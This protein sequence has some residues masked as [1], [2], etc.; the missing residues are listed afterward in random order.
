[1]SSTTPPEE[2]QEEVERPRMRLRRQAPVAPAEPLPDKKSNTVHI[3]INANASELSADA[4]STVAEHI[5]RNA[6][7]A[8]NAFSAVSEGMR[9]AGSLTEGL[10]GITTVNYG[11]VAT[12]EAAVARARQ[13]LSQ[14]YYGLESR[15]NRPISLDDASAAAGV[16]PTSRSASDAITL[17]VD[18]ARM[19]IADAAGSYVNVP[20]APSGVTRESWRRNGQ[21]VTTES[22]IPSGI[23][24]ALHRAWTGRINY[25]AI[26][27]RTPYSRHLDLDELRETPIA[28]VLHAMARSIFNE[29]EG[30]GGRY[31]GSLPV[32]VTIRN[33]F[34]VLTVLRVPLYVATFHYPASTLD[35]RALREQTSFGYVMESMPTGRGTEE[36]RRAGV[37]IGYTEEQ[38]THVLPRVVSDE[39]LQGVNPDFWLGVM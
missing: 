14:Q 3:T 17:G 9:R 15:I 30:R 18:F 23:E 12:R 11:S 29:L 8:S 39:M 13:D 27:G 5:R 32:S 31:T 4:L 37:A 16:S 21:P 22:V 1:M 7:S 6:A 28:S 35:A 26:E 20:A 2:P 36:L 24:R 25:V 38:F 10:R 19:D 34:M 33:V